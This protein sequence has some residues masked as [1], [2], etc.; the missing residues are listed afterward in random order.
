MTLRE[1]YDLNFFYFQI[2]RREHFITLGMLA[3]YSDCRDGRAD[4]A[5]ALRVCGPFGP[6][7][8]ESYSRRQNCYFNLFLEI[9]PFV[10]YYTSL[11]V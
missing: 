11:H 5:Q 10:L 2:D 1:N 8:F 6:R 4:N 3:F 9:S 7:G